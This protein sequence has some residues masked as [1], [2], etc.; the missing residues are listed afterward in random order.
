VAKVAPEEQGGHKALVVVVVK[1]V[2][3]AV[4]H[5]VQRAQRVHVAQRAHKGLSP[6]RDGFRPLGTSYWLPCCCS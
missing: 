2:R 3:V 6:E 4:A 5:A 1:V